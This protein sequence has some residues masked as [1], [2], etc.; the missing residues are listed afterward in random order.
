MSIRKHFKLQFTMDTE[1]FFDGN[2]KHEAQRILNVVKGRIR[3][4]FHS[5][6]IFD[7]NS[8]SIGQ[9]KIKVKE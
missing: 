6:K 1:P 4:G 2:G 7:K 9:W 8:N 3:L 5:G